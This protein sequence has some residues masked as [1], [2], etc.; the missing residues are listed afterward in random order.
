MQDSE[1]RFDC[2][3]QLQRN[4]GKRASCIYEYQILLSH[5]LIDY[6]DY[7]HLKGLDHQMDMAFV[8]MYG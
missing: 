7:W 6:F 8:D 4:S 5:I 3:G 1:I 2:P